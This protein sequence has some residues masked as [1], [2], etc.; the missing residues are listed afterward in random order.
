[1]NLH[2]VSEQLELELAFGLTAWYEPWGGRDPRGLTR[3]AEM[4]SLGALPPAG[5]PD[6]ARLQDVSERSSEQLDLFPHP[7]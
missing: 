7:F 5:L 2:H 1:M 4:F 6:D 3:S